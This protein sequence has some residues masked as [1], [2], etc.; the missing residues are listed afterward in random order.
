[1]TRTL[2]DLDDA[3]LLQAQQALGTGTK[4]ATINAAL[5]EVVALQARRS[6]LAAARGGAF[7][8]LADPEARG[9][10]WR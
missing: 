9:E 1:M 4:K 7:A 5:A 6:F 8:D 2:I 3:L 10:A